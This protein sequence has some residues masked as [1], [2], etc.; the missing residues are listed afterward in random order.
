MPS[1]DVARV[2]DVVR[3]DDVARV[4]GDKVPY[5]MI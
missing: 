4:D 5:D 2:D 1:L 3:V